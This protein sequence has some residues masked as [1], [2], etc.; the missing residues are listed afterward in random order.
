MSSKGAPDSCFS[1]NEEIHG[2]KNIVLG[3]I[4]QNTYVRNEVHAILMKK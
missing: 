1:L 3:F 2:E 4:A